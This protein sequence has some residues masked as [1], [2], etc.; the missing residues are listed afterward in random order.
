MKLAVLSDIHSNHHALKACLDQLERQHVEGLLFLGDYVSDCPYPEKTM[1]LIY[2]AADKYKTWFVRGNREELMIDKM[3][4]NIE[5]GR[6]QGSIR[7]TYEH[8]RKEDLL[9]FQKLPLV[10]TVEIDKM[11]KISMAHGDLHESRNKLYP[12][13]ENMKRLLSEL[14]APFHLCGHTHHPFIFQKGKKAVVN[15]GA[16][17]VPVSG[18]PKAE[19]AVLESDGQT[20]KPKLLKVEYD[21]EQ[22]IEEFYSSGLA[23]CAGVWARCVMGVLRTGRHYC[24]ECVELVEKYAEETGADF[25]DQGLWEKAAEE[26]GI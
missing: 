2:D 18:V 3:L 25:E 11:P 26:L 23:E 9:F 8:L 19:I 22:V 24:E 5:F 14:E 7:Y 15:P 6:T 12:D 20:W 1:D 13:N 17:G 21:T 4:G 10:Q 16:V